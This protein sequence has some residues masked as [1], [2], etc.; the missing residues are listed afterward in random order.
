MEP[1]TL[2]RLVQSPLLQREL[3]WAYCRRWLGMKPALVLPALL[4]AVVAAG[5]GHGIAKGLPHEDILGLAQFMVALVMA[6]MGVH[7]LM[8]APRVRQSL[9]DRARVEELLSSPIRS[10]EVA[11]ALLLGRGT[12]LAYAFGAALVG[13]LMA[14]V[15][16]FLGPYVGWWSLLQ[17]LFFVLPLTLALLA[18]LPCLYLEGVEA[19]LRSRVWMVTVAF[20]YAWVMAPLAATALWYLV[21]AQKILGFAYELG[22]TTMAQLDVIGLVT[23]LPPPL[24]LLACSYFM[25]RRRLRRAV[26]TMQQHLDAMM[27]EA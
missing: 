15:E 8:S 1:L 2:R 21:A 18:L 20:R 4:L 24:I 11:L 12:S 14:W 16:V 19:G 10:E 23:M 27:E 22:F 25:L 26:A 3:G 6:A 7:M 5:V 9:G 13:G 17:P